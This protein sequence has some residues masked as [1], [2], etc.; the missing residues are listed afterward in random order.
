MCGIFAILNNS[1]V[2]DT[3][4]EKE[5]K[6]KWFMKSQH[7]G[8][9]N[10]QLL[11]TRD[12]DYAMTLGFHRLAINGLNE[13]SNQPMFIRGIYLICN[14]EIYNHAFYEDKFQ[15]NYGISMT[16]QSDCEIIIHMYLQCGMMKTLE[17][18]DGEF[19]FVLFDTTNGKVF[20]ARDPFGV[21]PLYSYINHE[22]GKYAFASEMKSLVGLFGDDN[23]T[24]IL[25]LPPGCYA[26]YMYLVLQETKKIM[27]M[28]RREHKRYYQMPL[29]SPGMVWN[30]DVCCQ[31]IANLL[32]DAVIK[33]CQNTERPIAC[34]LSGGLDSSLV[35]ALANNYLK[36]YN[37]HHRLETYSIGL[38]GSTDLQY[39]R[40]AAEYLGTKHTEVVI[41]EEDIVAAIS[42]VIYNIESYDT[43]TIRASIGNYLVAKFISQRSDAK[44]ILNGDGSDELFGGYLYMKKCPDD[45]AFDEEIRRLLG[46]IHYYDVLRS[47]KSIS[48]NGLEARTPFL[49]KKLVN[50]VLQI[51]VLN[52]NPNH[53]KSCEKFLLRNSFTLANFQGHDGRQILPGEI[54]WRT[55]E[56]FSDGVTATDRSLYHILQEHISK[57][58][59]LE[60]KNVEIEKAHYKDEF[61]EHFPQ[62]QEIIPEYWMPRFIESEQ[63]DPSARTLECYN[64]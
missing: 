13:Q 23:N 49:D 44:V 42:E 28:F 34:L 63:N 54:L 51:P 29:T 37:S 33:R 57:I 60:E 48:S 7:R 59:S 22:E 4:E 52:R 8:P 45:I 38:K 41:T 17:L 1:T 21:R 62:C 50:Y 12:H 46:N 11:S 20:A 27:W 61:L 39:A 32:N 40:L 18:L 55:K 14:G 5:R 56:A 19:A 53:L 35:T 64:H 24:Y 26:E 30:Y 3:A 16:T 9:E 2:E 36:F 47:D 10:S 43:T 15:K 25:H 6:E 31:N 58:K